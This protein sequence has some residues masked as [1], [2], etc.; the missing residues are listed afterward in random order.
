MDDKVSGAGQSGQRD[1]RRTAGDIAHRLHA[2]R[3][4]HL[5]EKQLVVVVVVVV[6]VV[7]EVALYSEG[8]KGLVVGGAGLDGRQRLS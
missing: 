1:P 3:I 7:G 8:G 4:K 6:V 2:V 5:K